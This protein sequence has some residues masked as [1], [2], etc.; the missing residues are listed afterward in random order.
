MSDQTYMLILR[1]LHIGLGVFWA[2]SV[3]SFALFI[4][5]AV[6]ASG[7]EGGKFM[8]QLGKTGYPI[9]VMVAAIIS[10][11][12]GVLLI[13]KLSSG[14][15]A[16]WFTTPYAMVLTTGGVLAIIAF[17]IGFTVNRPAAARINALGSEIA[18]AGGPPTAEQLQQL[19]SLRKKLFIG[20]NVIALL[21]GLVVLAMS[22][23]RYVY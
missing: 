3:F 6:K 1:I 22:I 14:F 5:K 17:I 15:H 10:I 19:A 11:L 18:K 23:F 16:T 8:Q 21:L 12:A 7:P 20:T 4:T 9:A 2:G 13:A